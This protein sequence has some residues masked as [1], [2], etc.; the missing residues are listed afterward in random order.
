[1]NGR[2]HKEPA[3]LTPVYA[4]RPVDGVPPRP[5]N[6]SVCLVRVQSVAVSGDPQ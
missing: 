3:T 1:M 5:Y 6:V 2:G 4:C